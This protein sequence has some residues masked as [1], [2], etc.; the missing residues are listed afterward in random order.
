MR[1]DS[2]AIVTIQNNRVLKDIY[3]YGLSTSF[4]PVQGTQL[5]IIVSLQVRF[6]HLFFFI[7]N[8]DLSNLS[9]P[10][11]NGGK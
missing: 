11:V 10:P 9:I 3:F 4:S 6:A 2:F 1:N 5:S 8:R 7:E